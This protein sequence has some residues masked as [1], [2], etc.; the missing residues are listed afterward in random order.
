MGYVLVKKGEGDGFGPIA[1]GP[2]G[3][4]VL[5]GGGAG[6]WDRE[7]AAKKFGERAAQAGDPWARLGQMAAYGGGIYGGLSALNESLSSG[8]GGGLLNDIGMGTY[9]GYSTLSPLAGWAGDRATRRFGEKERAKQE[10]WEFDEEGSFGGASI[11]ANIEDGIRQRIEQE[12]QADYTGTGGDQRARNHSSAEPFNI[13]EPATPWG[14]MLA[15]KTPMR[16]N[17]GPAPPTPWY[18]N[19]PTGADSTQQTFGADVVGLPPAAPY[20]EN[21]PAHPAVAEFTPSAPV[22]VTQ[23]GTAD[24]RI[25]D[26]FNDRRS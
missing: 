14:Q 17:Y 23:S 2:Q 9:G 12:G 11:A 25:V 1:V 22:G 3:P 15:G 5:I 4:Q 8:Q 20:N 16:S 7:A 24:P 10:G 18:Q 21:E 6:G 26:W 19:P 13:S